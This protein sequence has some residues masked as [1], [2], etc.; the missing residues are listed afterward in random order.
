MFD[1]VNTKR[2]TIAIIVYCTGAPFGIYWAFWRTPTAGFAMQ[3][4]LLT[5]IVF[6]LDPFQMQKEKVK[7][8]RFWKA[9]LS[10]GAIVHPLFLAGLWH[11]DMTH[12]VFV[13][14]T[15]TV[16]FVG[17][18]TGIVEMIVLSEIVERVFLPKGANHT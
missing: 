10:G 8:W 14:G 17:I 6:M 9:M 1:Y 12:P 13:T 2:D 18:A 16:F 11:L 3:A 7:Q 4:Y 15:G 5:V